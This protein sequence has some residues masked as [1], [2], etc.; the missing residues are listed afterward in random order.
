MKKAFTL[1]ELLVVVLIIGILSAIALPQYNKAVEKSRAAEAIQ[2]LK[3]MHEQGELYQL[4]TSSG[5]VMVTNEELGIVFDGSFTCQVLRSG[6]VEICCNKYW[7]YENN[8]SGYSDYCP[9]SA[10]SPVA[11]RITKEVTDFNDIDHLYILE[12]RGCLDKKIVCGDSETYC[13]IFNGKDN[14][15]N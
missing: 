9:N 11:L 4:A 13:K 10:N 3:Y 6:E 1:I 7:C 5:G 15:I 8:G 12:F 2:V 14:P